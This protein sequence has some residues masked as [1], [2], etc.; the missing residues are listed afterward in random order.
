MASATR[1]FSNAFSVESETKAI[2][3]E[4]LPA[5]GIGRLVLVNQSAWSEFKS[6][7]QSELIS[8]QVGQPD[9]A[10]ALMNASCFSHCGFSLTC[11][12]SMCN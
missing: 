5:V 4:V 11:L 10:L 7:M 8:L 3:C 9:K 2:M 12:V 1:Q 6:L